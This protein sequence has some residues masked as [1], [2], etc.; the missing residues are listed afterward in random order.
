[1]IRDSYGQVAKPATVNFPLRPKPDARFGVETWRVVGGPRA[2]GSLS[3]PPH[4]PPMAGAGVRI[5]RLAY[6]LASPARPTASV[7]ERP[8]CFRLKANGVRYGRTAFIVRK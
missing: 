8:V 1:M 4:H 2:P 7:P 5:L 6:L 3:Q